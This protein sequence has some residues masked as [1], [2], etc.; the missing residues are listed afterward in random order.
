MLNILENIIHINHQF[1]RPLSLPTTLFII[2]VNGLLFLLSMW[3]ANSATESIAK[4]FQSRDPILSPFIPRSKRCA[5]Y[6]GRNYTQLN[7]DSFLPC[8][9]FSNQPR[10]LRADAQTVC[11]C[12]HSADGRCRRRR[13]LLLLLLGPIAS[14]HSP[15][16]THRFVC[17]LLL[18]II[19]SG[20]QSSL[21]HFRL[22]LS[23]S[24]HRFSSSVRVLSLPLVFQIC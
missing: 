8:R 17:F 15:I 12:L 9:P 18:F 14:T 3:L 13:L 4:S 5:P 11:F 20:T 22:H 24:P 10:V 23:S 21:H 1:T 2:H 19:C 6:F 7:E 16:S